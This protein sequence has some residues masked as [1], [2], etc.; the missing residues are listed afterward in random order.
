MTPSL[1]SPLS[2]YGEN[3]D[4][5]LP[6]PGSDYRILK[7]LTSESISHFPGVLYFKFDICHFYFHNFQ[8]IIEKLVVY[9]EFTP[10][11]IYATCQITPVNEKCLTSLSVKVSRVSKTETRPKLESPTF[12]EFS[13]NILLPRA[14]SK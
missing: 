13:K 3:T 5:F 7:L 11:I 2:R 9:R 8:D 12:L 1:S 10:R 6:K 4:T 14:S